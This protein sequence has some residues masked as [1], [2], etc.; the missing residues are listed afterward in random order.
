MMKK[1]LI[2]AALAL[3]LTAFA[4][5]VPTTF[6]DTSLGGTDVVTFNQL[7]IS[8]GNSLVTLTDTNGNGL[9]DIGDSFVEGGMVAGVGFTDAAD[10]PIPGT[11]L[12]QIGG[13]QLWAVFDPLVGFVSG[14]TIGSV[15]PLTIQT[16][17]ASFIVPSGVTIYYDTNVNDGFTA[18]SAV[19]GTATM[20]TPESN[21]VVT[22]TTGIGSPSETGSCLLQFEFD[23]AGV[24][25]P[26]VW[27]AFGGQDIGDL[28]GVKLRVDMNVDNFE[29][30][31]FSPTY[32]VAGGTQE[33]ALDHN[34]SASFVPE[35][36]S[37]A[38]LGLGL[39]GLGA[40]R[41]R[42]ASV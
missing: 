4:T 9:L 21:C 27:T 5:V 16:F 26:G 19:I 24:T 38:L 36:A 17:T 42:K 2:A 1:T 34:G 14:A 11:N 31:F 35:P 20:P 7:Q 3:P 10:N 25:E 18:G 15:G 28:D 30:N 37:L 33:I 22:R 41:R 29:P 13:Y 40:I 6:N 23:A 32:A 8:G 12:N 39:V